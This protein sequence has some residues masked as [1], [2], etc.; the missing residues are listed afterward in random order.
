MAPVQVRGEVLS[1]RRV[2]EYHALTVVAPGIA[3]G[4]RPGGPR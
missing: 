1:T 2:G 3:D 4:A